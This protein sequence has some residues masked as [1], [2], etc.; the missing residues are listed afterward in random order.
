MKLCQFISLEA[1]AY[2][3]DVT[4]KHKSLVFCAVSKSIAAVM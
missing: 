4:S 3:A 2:L 1:Y